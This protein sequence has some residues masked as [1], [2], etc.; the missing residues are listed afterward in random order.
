M[1]KTPPKKATSAVRRLGLLNAA[2]CLLLGQPSGAN[3][4]HTLDSLDPNN[5]RPLF[6]EVTR[7]AMPPRRGASWVSLRDGL[8]TALVTAGPRY[9]SQSW[10]L[11]QLVVSPEFEEDLTP[12]LNSVSRAA[13][14]KGAKRVFI[15]LVHGDPTTPDVRRAGFF[16]CFRETLYRGTP[17]RQASED[18][19]ALRLREP[20]DD[21]NLFR[22]YNATTPADIRSTVG[23]TF[24]DW[25][26][27]IETPRGRRT[28]HV[29]ES[30]GGLTGWV[31]CARRGPT[32]LLSLTFQSSAEEG[33]AS[34]VEFGLGCLTAAADVFCLVPE[35]QADLGR[36]L[37]YHGFEAV[38]E[39]EV[40]VGSTAV[41]AE[42]D[43]RTRATVTST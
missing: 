7:T 22:L 5:G 11:R 40:M 29:L 19:G 39:F 3:R 12:L 14:S 32:G 1:S 42:Q 35:H 13:A 27:S 36:V 10:E 2:R 18:G 25:Q 37:T 34:A 26:S 15:R 21:Y 23:M 33:I 38:S 31:R 20:H 24:E 9:R 17:M 28:E 16:P 41:R 43:S 6:V 8:P 30:A 4:A